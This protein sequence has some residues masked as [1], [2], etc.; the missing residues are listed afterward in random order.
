MMAPSTRALLRREPPRRAVGEPAPRAR[1]HEP[2][3]GVGERTGRAYMR[4]G[5]VPEKVTI[6]PI[7]CSSFEFIRMRQSS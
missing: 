6:Q 3:I 2:I 1:I 7:G 4:F 5:E